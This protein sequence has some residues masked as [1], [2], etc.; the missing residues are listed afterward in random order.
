MSSLLITYE[1]G[2]PRACASSGATGCVKYWKGAA[3][4]A[5]YVFARVEQVIGD[6]LELLVLHTLSDN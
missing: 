1:A 3:P 2:I 6:L 5:S 4:A